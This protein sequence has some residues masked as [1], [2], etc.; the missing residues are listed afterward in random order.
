MVRTAINLV[1][2]AQYETSNLFLDLTFI[3]LQD[4]MLV[5]KM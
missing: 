1:Y 4:H 5:S 2:L 3:I